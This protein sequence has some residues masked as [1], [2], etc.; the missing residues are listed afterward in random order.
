MRWSLT[1]TLLL[2]SCDDHLIGKGVDR[3]PCLRENPLTYENFG[4]AIIGKYCVGCHSSFYE[5]E[6]R[7]GAPPEVN[8]DTW[9]DIVEWAERIHV[10][11]V[12]TG[13][14]PPT[15]ALNDDERAMLDEWLWCEVFPAT[16][17][18]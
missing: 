10:R 9:T 11:T 14:M 2:V 12:L 16:G 8:L 18:L 1:L 6:D 17:Q 4:H 15:G 7:S 5:G 3:P 13:D